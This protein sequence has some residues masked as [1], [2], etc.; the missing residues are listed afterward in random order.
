MNVMFFMQKLFSAQES[1]DVEDISRTLLH[2]K[3]ALMYRGIPFDSVFTEPNGNL[4]MDGEQTQT[5]K[6]K[7][8]SKQRNMN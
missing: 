4:I 7:S 5:A 1:S 8:I 6:R 2:L 3:S